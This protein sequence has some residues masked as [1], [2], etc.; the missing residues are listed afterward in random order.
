MRNLPIMVMLLVLLSSCATTYQ[1][2]SFSGGYSETQLSENIF[3]I[4][5]KGNGFTS[6][7]RA[8]DFS[9][10][11]SA[12]VALEHGFQYFVI[13]DS[14]QESKLGTYTMPTTTYT[15]GSA[16]VS[17][18]YAYGNI[19]TNTYGG[20]TYLTSKPRATNTIFCFE[21]RP[22]N[23]EL[24]FDAQFISNSIRQKYQLNK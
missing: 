19:A 22:E 6:S 10:L 1:Q 14:E 7:E 9:L 18:N 17:G 11:R 8:S 3:Q 24:V 12:E 5:F 2:N 21:D 4:L 16:Y 15:T 23:G 20:Q 13:I